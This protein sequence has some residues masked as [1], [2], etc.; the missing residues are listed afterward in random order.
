LGGYTGLD[1]Q[2]LVFAKDSLGKP[3][4]DHESASWLRFSCSHSYE[5]AVFAVASDRE[6]GV[7]VERLSGDI[8]MDGI[9][10]RFFTESERDAI[11]CASPESRTEAFFDTWTRK[12]AYLKG[13]GVGVTGLDSTSKPALVDSS[14][15][16][17]DDSSREP[18]NVDRIW[19]VTRFSAGQG[20]AAAVAVKGQ[21]M[22]V[23]SCAKWMAP[24]EAQLGPAPLDGS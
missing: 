8:P 1:P 7:D 11:A 18:S 16:G 24:A 22:V 5:I 2:D 19:S 9:T 20:Y 10:Q 21:S 14:Q 12:E 17:I 13:L 3:R 15:L 6:V 4:L 23:P